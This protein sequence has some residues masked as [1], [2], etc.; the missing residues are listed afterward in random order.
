M[1]RREILN[2][3]EKI[4]EI[5]NFD[6]E[7]FELMGVIAIGVIDEEMEMKKESSRERIELDDF[8]DWF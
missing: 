3:K 6:P 1:A 4:N 2:K 8:I 7:R 5:F